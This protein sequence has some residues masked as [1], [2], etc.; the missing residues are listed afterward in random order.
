M[1]GRR[2][3]VVGKQNAGA[4]YWA[5]RSENRNREV[6]FAVGGP[7]LDRADRSC[8][9][10]TPVIPSGGV[11]TGDTVSTR[12]EKSHPPEAQPGPAKADSAHVCT[13]AHRRLIIPFADIGSSDGATATP[14]TP[15][16]VI[17][18]RQLHRRTVV[19]HSG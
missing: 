11:S 6:M 19:A 10:V 15:R 4:W 2:D 9:Q 17:R 13:R 7:I 8:R 5:V 16:G 3:Q 1:A 12:K 18:S 14:F